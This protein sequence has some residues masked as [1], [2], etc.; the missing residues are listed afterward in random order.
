MRRQAQP[1][2]VMRALVAATAVAAA[3]VL[4]LWGY[5]VGAATQPHP[6]PP[7]ELAEIREP[8]RRI[9]IVDGLY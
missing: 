4:A 7:V 1:L 5:I 9:W 2:R 3:L 8:Y 6:V